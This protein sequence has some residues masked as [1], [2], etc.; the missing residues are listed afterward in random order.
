MNLTALSLEGPL[1][2]TEF[3][4]RECKVNWRT[5]SYGEL[6]RI[7]GERTPDQDRYLIATSAPESLLRLLSGAPAGSVVVLLLGDEAY[8][9]EALQLAALESVHVIFKQ[10]SWDRLNTLQYL[11]SCFLFVLDS[12]GTGVRFRDILKQ[13]V[14]G[15]R[16]RRQQKRWLQLRNKLEVLPLGYASIFAEALA[17]QW[18][19]GHSSA[20]LLTTFNNL[21]TVKRDYDYGFSGD[22]GQAQRQ[23]CLSRAGRTRSCIIRWTK[24]PW[25]GGLGTEQAKE[26]VMSLLRVRF[27]LCPPGGISNES[28]RVTESIICGALPLVL[29][30]CVSQGARSS[31]TM[32]LGLIEASWRRIFRTSFNMS[33]S[34]RSELLRECRARLHEEFNQVR[35]K[36][37]ASLT[38]DDAGV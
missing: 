22:R 3:L 1:S 17:L 9:A 38:G 35:L 26:Y 7:L 20:S 12:F 37:H 33:E 32:R 27:S 30:S 31:S 24:G 6:E 28:F 2:E 21:E 14:K 11:S 15:A 18:T 13:F 5:V 34:R 25:N 29:E 8:A 4:R 19:P 23:V 16:V 10:H 36:I